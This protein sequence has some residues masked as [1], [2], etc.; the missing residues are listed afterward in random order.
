MK[1]G[2]SIAVILS[3]FCFP[4][5]SQEKKT[6]GTETATKKHAGGKDETS[7][8][9]LP[10]Q[11]LYSELLKIKNVNFNKKI[12]RNGLGDIL[13][14]EFE[15][16][17]EI[18]DPQDIYIFVIATF[19]KTEKTSSSFEPP[20]PEKERLRS[21][22]PYPYDLKNF[23]YPGSDGKTKLLKQPKNT[24]A[25]IDPKTGKAYRLKDKIFMSTDHL[26]KYRNNYFYFNMVMIQ[27]YDSNGG[28]IFRQQ[29]KIEGVRR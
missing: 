20:I 7:G 13:E 18:D 26:A 14:V 4:L 17:N 6:A 29:Y 28:P 1:K 27:V 15:V 3:I 16:A 12:D 24:K 5:Y 8:H 21:F 9:N 19:E 22:V 25:G 23:E 11:A 10:V 2:I